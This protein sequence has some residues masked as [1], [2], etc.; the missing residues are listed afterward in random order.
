[1]SPLL[2]AALAAQHICDLHAEAAEFRLYRRAI[3]ERCPY[4]PLRQLDTQGRH[5]LR[6]GTSAR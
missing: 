4:A 6:A 5:R 1:M 2:S 3:P